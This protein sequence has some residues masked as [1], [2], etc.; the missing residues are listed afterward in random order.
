MTLGKTITAVINNVTIAAS[1][2][3]VSSTSVDLTQAVD[4]GIAYSLVFNGSASQGCQIQIFAEELNAGSGFTIGTYDN[5]I[6]SCDV[7]I[8]AGHSVFGFFQCNRT[9]RYVKIKAVNLDTGQS[10]TGFC[11][12]AVV[13]TP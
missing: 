11:A 5:M 12:Y 6:D 7:P 1:G 13:Q 4:F 3:Q 10:I 9:P 8:S 2:N